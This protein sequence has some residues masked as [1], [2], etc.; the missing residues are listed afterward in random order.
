MLIT[1]FQGQGATGEYIKRAA[2][3][4]AMEYNRRVSGF[5]RFS[6][7]LR[8]RP[9]DSRRRGFV[10]AG[11]IFCFAAILA[12][13]PLAA[14]TKSPAAS[15]AR[16]GANAGPKA[17]A[18]LARFRAR[19]Q[20]TL[21]DEH[22]QKAYW[23]ILIADRDTGETLY[24][25]NSNHF[26]T[27]ASNTKIFTTAFAA[28][29][30]GPGYRFHTTLESD[31]AL[32]PGGRL[33]GDLVL[34]GRGD[35]DLSNRKFPFAG[36]VEHDGPAEK[37]LAELA[38][39]AAAKGLKE[40]D[41][42]LVADDSYFPYDPYP[43]GWSD[44]DLFFTFGAPVSAIA[45]NDNTLGLEVSAG[46]AAGDPA[47]VTV[48]PGVAVDGFGREI[49]TRVPGGEP[50]FA[51][52]RQPGENFLLLR[53][54]IPIGHAPAKLEFA[55]QHP[56]EIAGLALKQLLEA[57]GIRVTGNVRVHHGPPPASNEAGDPL[58]TPPDPAPALRGPNSFVLAEHDSPPLIETV[59]VT[60][61][62]SENL[63]AELLLRAAGLAKLG[64]GST[65]AGLKSERDFLKSAGIADGDVVLSDG[66]GL[67]ENNL[68]TPRATL[69]LLRWV[70]QQPWG[71]DYISTFPIAGVDGTLETRL[72]G[73]PAVGRIQAKT[74]THAHVRAFSGFATTERGEHLV[75]SIFV[76]HNPQHGH[77]ASAAVD[78]IAVA[79]V[80]TL[81]QPPPRKK[82]K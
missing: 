10:V 7:H 42:D 44:G 45:F 75:F 30:L 15:A 47:V 4:E 58:P 60:N 20:A 82:K 14:Q 26:F 6:M 72:V 81:G 62:M 12:A 23:G 67:S 46:P 13:R 64:I 79:M 48:T 74:G 54:S 37:I 9:S 53:G 69:A 59:R 77:D 71:A 34:V 55:M 29:A 39:S 50:D 65:A 80:E 61:K 35:P 49:I 18:D 17:R 38:D 22:A 70:A 76:N 24:E 51:V 5:E 31:A 11:C 43:A 40:I 21:S 57:R 16:P 33:Q 56:A 3:R 73:T 41:G 28:S 63:H 2:G 68:V 78:A 8:F 32:A 19:V 36:K 25:L 66:S 27:P 52:V 1:R